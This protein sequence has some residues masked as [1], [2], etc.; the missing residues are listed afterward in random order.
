M[1][2]HNQQ[3]DTVS[4]STPN[5][6]SRD[7]KFHLEFHLFDKIEFFNRVYEGLVS[8]NRLWLTFCLLN[9]WEISSYHICFSIAELPVPKSPRTSRT[10]D[11]GV[12]GNRDTTVGQLHRSYRESN[13]TWYGNVAH[14][15]VSGHHRSMWSHDCSLYPVRD[16]E[17]KEKPMISIVEKSQ[18]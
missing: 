12:P 7:W 6:S 13:M 1:S 10:R 4:W 5:L 9:Y 11:W 16:T 3:Q 2:V 14:F 18:P 15:K 8:S 17:T